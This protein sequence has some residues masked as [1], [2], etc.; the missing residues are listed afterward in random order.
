MNL[1]TVNH[2]SKQEKLKKWMKYQVYDEE[3]FTQQV[4]S[5]T[6]NDVQKMTFKIQKR[7]LLNKLVIK[8]NFT[9]GSNGYDADGNTGGEKWVGLELLDN[10]RLYCGKQLIYTL[11][12][13]DNLAMFQLCSTT[14]RRIYTDACKKDSFATVSSGT[15]YDVYCPLLF[16]CFE[17]IDNLLDTLF[18]Q[19]LR[20]ELDIMPINQCIYSVGTNN[21]MNSITILS[22]HLVIDDY[23]KF[24]Q[25]RY[26]GETYSL[27]THD[28]FHEKT[29]TTSSIPQG[30]QFDSGKVELCCKYKDIEQSY[31][32]ISVNGIYDWMNGE[33][34]TKLQIYDQNK[35][36]NQANTNIEDLILHHTEYMKENHLK[37]NSSP[38]ET[39]V[40]VINYG[41]YSTL[42]QS[43]SIDMSES[44]YF[45]KINF[46]SSQGANDGSDNRTYNIFI[47][48]NYLKKIVFD[49][50]GSVIEI[51]C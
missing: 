10:A 33:E 22:Q 8:F 32:F 13:S 2:F 40:R 35:V 29:L 12:S 3:L 9:Y 38:Y 51:D 46:N 11:S 16:G 30:T 28:N 49:K 20:L 6:K 34:I 27:I 25:E 37:D 15:T 4:Y 21:I 24:Y 36:I 44:T 50:K 42:D 31:F 45:Y 1:E 14:D 19:D 5:S 23:K 18:I 41:V 47:T 26:T 48:H 17:E 7:G 39:L 43:N